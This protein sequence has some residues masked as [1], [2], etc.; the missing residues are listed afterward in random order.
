MVL[1]AINLSGNAGDVDA[2]ADVDTDVD[3][4]VDTG[5]DSDVDADVD[6]GVDSDI[7]SEIGTG[8]ESELDTDVDVNADTTG[9]LDVPDY[10]VG[11]DINDEVNINQDTSNSGGNLG[12]INSLNKIENGSNSINNKG[13]ELI[14]TQNKAPFMLIFSMYLLWFG[15]LGMI[16]APR[17]VN[18]FL[19]AGLVLSIPIALARLLAILWVK[20]SRN[21]FYKVDQGIELIGKKGTVKIEVT[22]VGGTVSVQSEYL[23]QQIPVK[24]LYPKSIFHQNEE[25][26]ICDYRNRT[27]YV[28]GFPGSIRNR[29]NIT[30][31]NNSRN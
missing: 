14:I 10:D 17:L 21:V 29:K 9:D 22:A 1:S 5:V 15:A 3:A 8:I 7:G 6:T 31:K 24:S 4:D 23:T 11:M 20:I 30:L 13:N 16:L 19:W 25:V 26:Y 28:D 2:D 27:Y 12:D 18:P